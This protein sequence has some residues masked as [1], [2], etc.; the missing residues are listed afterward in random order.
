MNLHMIT[1]FNTTVKH[2]TGPEQYDFKKIDDIIW[3]SVQRDPEGYYI[4]YINVLP[5]PGWSE[6]FPEDT[7]M[8]ATGKS[9]VSREGHVAPASYYSLEYRRQVMELLRAYVRHIK[10]QP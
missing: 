5:Y 4:I 2:W 7:A 6:K 3:N 8:N 10:A 1:L 9:A